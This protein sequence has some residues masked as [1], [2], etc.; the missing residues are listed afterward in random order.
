MGVSTKNRGGVYL[1]PPQII[2]LFIGFG[3]IMFTIHFGGKILLFLEGPPIYDTDPIPAP[4]DRPC[5][6]SKSWCQLLVTLQS[7][8]GTPIWRKMRRRRP[9]RKR[10]WGVS[11]NSSFFCSCCYY[12][13]WNFFFLFI[14]I[15]WICHPRVSVVS[16]CL[17]TIYMQNYDQKSKC[18][19][20]NPRWL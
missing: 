1:K 16:R 11:G 12:L 15:F 14:F 10:R 19:A 8:P 5:R 6:W 9:W 20:N 3:T 7:W 2:H 13:F 4:T 18:R 17:L